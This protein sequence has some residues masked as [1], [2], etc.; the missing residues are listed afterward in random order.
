[1]PRRLIWSAI[2]FS[3]LLYGIL[4]YATERQ[5]TLQPFSAALRRPIVI[6]LYLIALAVYGTAFVVSN[7]MLRNAGASA[8]AFVAQLALFEAVTILGLVAAFIGHDWRLYLPAWMLA[9]V[10]FFTRYPSDATA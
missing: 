5:Y 6:V 2:V 4:A 3:T 7:A 8:G 10:G 1:M 9:L